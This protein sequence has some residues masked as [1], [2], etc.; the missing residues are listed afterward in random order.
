MTHLLVDILRG[1]R[2]VMLHVYVLRLTDAGRQ[3]VVMSGGRV[4]LGVV[5]HDCVFVRVRDDVEC[6]QNAAV[7]VCVETRKAIEL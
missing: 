5:R 7:V 1:V 6:L 2:I 4:V 3:V